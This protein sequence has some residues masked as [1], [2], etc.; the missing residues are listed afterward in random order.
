MRLRDGLV[1]A[2]L[3]GLA[4]SLMTIGV[5]RVA[6]SPGAAASMILVLWYG[7]R[8][9]AGSAIVPPRRFR[10]ALEQL[11]VVGLAFLGVYW[12]TR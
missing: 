5:V 10:F 1:L 8:G 7:L 12:V 11:A 6:A 9:V 2:G 4:V 3:T